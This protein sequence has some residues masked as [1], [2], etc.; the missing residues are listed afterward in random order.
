MRLEAFLEKVKSC[1]RGFKDPRRGSNKSYTM[2][3]IGMAAYSVFHMQSP[4]FL[5]HQAR[6]KQQRNQHNGRT[7]FGF[8][9]IPSDNHIRQTLDTVPPEAMGAFFEEVVKELDPETWTVD[10]RWLIALDGVTFFSSS[11]VH[12]PCCLKK[13]SA[14]G[15]VT[16]S[17]AALCAVLVHPTEQHVI[18]LMPFFIQNEDGTQKQDCEINAAKR[19]LDQHADFLK[20]HKAILI[21]DDLFSR[22]PFIEK[23]NA[24]EGVDFIF[25]SKPSSHAFL[26]DWV[27][28]L[29]TPDKQ[30]LQVA[31]GAFA[32]HVHN[33]AFALDVPLNGEAKAPRVS[34]FEM[35]VDNKKG[36]RLYTNSFV[37][38]LPLSARNIHA[39]ACWGRNRWR[40]E[41]E[42]F[43]VLKTKGYHLEHNFGHGSRF[44]ANLLATLNIVAFTVHTLWR[45]VHPLFRG[46]WSAFSSRKQFFQALSTLTLFHLF[47]SWENLLL[48]M[49]D[50]LEIPK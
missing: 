14:S 15:H 37:T 20:A 23:V 40:I 9:H 4:S 47:D 41:N 22:A 44:L 43:N 3:E 6:M 35:A 21:A 2:E 10:G 27:Q 45:L 31:D 38:S 1:V 39:I 13:Q 26:T 50:G 25:V 49:A 7:L 8:E 42:A 30:T 48:F 34:F 19:W 24:L 5:A 12:C 36:R 11:K 29:E 16:Y 18:P 32:S 28:A 33:Y 17:H 46:A